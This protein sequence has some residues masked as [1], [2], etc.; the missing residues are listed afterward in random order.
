M[1]ILRTTLLRKSVDTQAHMAATSPHNLKPA[2][3]PAQIEVGNYSKG[4]ATIAG[5]NISIENPEGSYRRPEWPMMTAHYGYIK[6]AEGNDGDHLDVFIKP[7]TP[8]DWDGKFYVIDQSNDDGSFDEHKIMLG[9]STIDE[10]RR[11]Y[12]NHYTNGWSKRVIGIMQMSQAKFKQWMTGDL[13]KPA[14]VL[15]SSLLHRML[16]AEWNEDDHPRGE[17]GRFGEGGGGAA[18]ANV[19]AGIKEYTARGGDLSSRNTATPT[20]R[21]EF[22][23]WIDA[24]RTGD[25]TTLWQGTAYSTSEWDGKWEDLTKPGNVIELPSRSFSEDRARTGGY[26]GGE[27]PVKFEL[28]GGMSG[29]DIQQHSVYKEEQEHIASKGNKYEV[30]SWDR[31]SSGTNIIRI[32]EAA[33]KKSLLHTALLKAKKPKGR[34]LKAAPRSLIAARQ[35]KMTSKLTTYFASQKSRIISQV[36]AGYKEPVKTVKLARMLKGEW[37][38]EDHPRGENGQWGDNGSGK[39]RIPSFEEQMATLRAFQEKKFTGI[40]G[41]A[42]KDEVKEFELKA[43][44]IGVG[45]LKSKEW[46]AESETTVVNKNDLFA[47]PGNRLDD[48]KVDS[49]RGKAQGV[50]PRAYKMGG[51][52]YLIDGHHRTMAQVKDGRQEF[53]VSVI[54]LDTRVAKTK[55]SRVNFGHEDYPRTEDGQFGGGGGEKTRMLKA[56]KTPE[57]LVA[58]VALE[59]WSSIVDEEITPEIEAAFNAAGM[60][61]LESLNVPITSSMTGLVNE[62]ASL[63]AEEL[64]AQLVTDIDD[65]TREMIRSKVQQAVDEGWDSARLSEELADSRAFDP[66]RAELIADYELGSALEAGNLVGW[67]ASGV[68]QGKQWLT[69]DDSLVSDECQMN[70]DQGVIGLDEQFSSGDDVPLAHPYCR[71]VV[72]GVV[73]DQETAVP[74]E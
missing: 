36:L 49:Y 51:K 35:K 54:D 13:T 50:L 28:V 72:V 71:C 47:Y 17:S 7:G 53:K 66:A 32:K 5:L 55:F 43:D 64:S 70:A 62:R 31:T 33:T 15:K 41:V 44:A 58:Q 52:Y 69:A 38:E 59:G 61:A 30:V 74:E 12:L 34:Q 18:S 27:E 65:S 39:L 1:D 22:E 25:D 48:K 29:R 73:E 19:T 16:K 2:P 45:N 4:H 9:Y 14:G 3:T 40:G 42:T 26:K 37:N 10:A 67:Q 20:Q 56:A 24:G 6:G 21:A 46:T 11:A 8:D 23:A 68:V 63:Y 60:S 57:E